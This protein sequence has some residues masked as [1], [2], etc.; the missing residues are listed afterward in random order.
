MAFGVM[1]YLRC[2][3]C[4]VPYNYTER[5]FRLVD[6]RIQLPCGWTYVGEQIF[7]EG[8]NLRRAPAGISLLKQLAVTHTKND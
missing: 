5:L 3:H 1:G 6:G 7:C 4:D 8:C 2:D